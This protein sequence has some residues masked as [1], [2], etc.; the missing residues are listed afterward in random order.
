MGHSWQVKLRLIN[1]MYIRGQAVLICM[2]VQSVIPVC[3]IGLMLYN[4][5]CVLL[6]LIIPGLEATDC[7]FSGYYSVLYLP[8]YCQDLRAYL[9]R[10]LRI[11]CVCVFVYVCLCVCVCLCLYVYVCVCVCVCVC[12]TATFQ[13]AFLKGL[14]TKYVSG[15][16][17]LRGSN[18]LVVHHVSCIVFSSSSG[19]LPWIVGR[20]LGRYSMTWSLLMSRRILLRNDSSGPPIR[21]TWFQHHSNTVAWKL[22]IRLSWL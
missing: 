17:N 3:C 10:D 12:V 5:S 7:L 1:V 13:V 19:A 8:K 6:Q 15:I 22:Y 18:H 9:V 2:K 21:P 4:M 16:G 11:V 14:L 20:F